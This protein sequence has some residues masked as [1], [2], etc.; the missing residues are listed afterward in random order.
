MWIEMEVLKQGRTC[1]V[2]WTVNNCVHVLTLIRFVRLN[3]NEKC[4][5]MNANGY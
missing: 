5:E 4:G 1:E 3:V 2:N